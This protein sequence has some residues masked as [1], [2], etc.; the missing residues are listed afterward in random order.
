MG[1]VIIAKHKGKKK[2]SAEQQVVKISGEKYYWKVL[3]LILC[4][5]LLYLNITIINTVISSPNS[6]WD[7]RVYM[8]GVDAFNHDK[9]PYILTNIQDYVGDTLPYVYPP[10]MLIFFEIFYFFQSIGLYRLFIVSLLALSIY[11]VANTDGKP[12]YIL[13]VTLLITG[14]FSVYWNFLT[15]NFAI[16]SLFLI[17]VMFWLFSKDKLKES[18]IVN[19]LMTSITL[20]PAIFSGAFLTLRKSYKEMLTLICVVGVTFGIIF[21]LSFIFNPAIVQSFIQSLFG[22]TS[23]MYADRGG[24]SNPTPY[25]LFGYIAQDN[26][27]ITGIISVIYIGIVLGALYLFWKNNNDYF[28]VYS[29]GFL[30]MFMLLIR[31]KPYSFVMAVIPVYFLIKDYSYKLKIIILLVMSLFPFLMYKDYWEKFLPLPDLIIYYAQSLSLFIIFGIIWYK[32]Y[33]DSKK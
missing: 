7:Y 12:E 3:C 20:Y 17:S 1:G 19:G 18:A 13:Y 4:G 14:F 25:F 15:G 23:Q 26:A 24:M 29:F 30:S 5:I 28:K 11:F 8:G 2:Q 9:D 16:M 22:S 27:I 21:G 31:I 10:H 6:G 32:N 33:L